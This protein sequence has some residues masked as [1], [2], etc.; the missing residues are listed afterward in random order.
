MYW[1]FFATIW[2]APNQ[3]VFLYPL[4]SCFRPRHSDCRQQHCRIS[5]Q[6]SDYGLELQPFC[7]SKF[8]LPTGNFP[9][10]NGI[11]LSLTG[12][13]RFPTAI[14]VLLKRDIEV[15]D[16]NMVVA[17]SNMAVADRKIPFAERH[18]CIRRLKRK[19]RAGQCSVILP[20][21]SW[22]VPENVSPTLLQSVQSS[23]VSVSVLLCLNRS[24]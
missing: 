24:R 13:V 5:P 18:T 3:A 10:P 21:L 4:Y 22:S 16:S 2:I 20:F 23:E 15:A 19:R 7:C 17:D 1:Y 8:R 6:Y 12:R 14:S 9:F 11:F